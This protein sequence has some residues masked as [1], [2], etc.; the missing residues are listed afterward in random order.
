M[1]IGGLLG[2]IGRRVENDRRGMGFWVE[3]LE[4]CMNV[5]ERPDI[6]RDP[7]EDASLQVDPESLVSQWCQN[8]CHRNTR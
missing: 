7:E 8:R 4:K 2:N 5:L 3:K 1:L 6:T